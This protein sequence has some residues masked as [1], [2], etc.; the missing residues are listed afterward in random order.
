MHHVAHAFAVP[1]VEELLCRTPPRWVPL[2]PPVPRMCCAGCWKWAFVN[3]WR[4]ARALHLTVFESA[5]EGPL[6][7]QATLEGA[8]PWPHTLPFLESA[9]DYVEVSLAC[10]ALK[11]WC[12]AASD[13]VLARMPDLDASHRRVSTDVQ[14]HLFRCYAE[15]RH[16]AELLLKGSRGRW[17]RR[18]AVRLCDDMVHR[19]TE[20]CIADLNV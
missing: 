10:E 6:P 13:E 11:D 9:D 5:D 14:Q 16:V 12:G 2:K 8:V 17:D 7:G 3:M 4:C 19:L 1:S 20:L 18:A 15:V